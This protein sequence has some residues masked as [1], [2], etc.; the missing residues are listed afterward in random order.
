MDL[1][2]AN[3]VHPPI[4]RVVHALHRHH[5]NWADQIVPGCRELRRHVQDP[6]LVHAMDPSKQFVPH[7][8][9]PTLKH[10]RRPCP[11]CA[12]GA[13]RRPPAR[14]ALHHD[15]GAGERRRVLRRER[16]DPAAE[17]VRPLAV[18]VRNHFHRLVVVGSGAVDDVEERGGAA[19]LLIHGI[20][21]VGE[22]RLVVAPRSFRLELVTGV[23]PGGFVSAYTPW[24][25][26]R[27][28]ATPGR[29]SKSCP[30]L[31]SLYEQQQLRRVMVR[32]RI[33]LALRAARAPRR[34]TVSMCKSMKDARGTP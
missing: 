13:G 34:G 27:S 33:P 21:V 19:E 25:R 3:Q 24:I 30:S 12:A 1:P 14:E 29:S 4:L 31:G 8:R 15:G 10:G 23:V 32:L 28:L 18:P 26:T 17:R 5:R 2:A 9:P 7:P 20:V 22:R 11:R 16:P 6:L